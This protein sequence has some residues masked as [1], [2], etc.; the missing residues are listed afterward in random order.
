MI[1]IFQNKIRPETIQLGDVQAA[2]GGVKVLVDVAFG[3]LTWRFVLI[4][5]IQVIAL[6][7][8]NLLFSSFPVKLFLYPPI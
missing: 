2:I 3:C 7:F 6:Q 4:L 8:Q 5:C 1:A